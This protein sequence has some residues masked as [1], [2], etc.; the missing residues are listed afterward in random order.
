M[1]VKKIDKT[2]PD[3]AYVEGSDCIDLYVSHNEGLGLKLYNKGDTVVVNFGVAIELP[4]GYEAHIYPRSSTF[5]NT[6]LI[7]TNSVGIIDNSYNGDTDEWKGMFY[8]TQSGYLE[9]G[10]RIAQ[11]RLCKNQPKLDLEF[12]ETLG[13][14]DRGGYGST[15]K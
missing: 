3:I 10:Q 1:K 2:L 7:L 8:A 13:N 6:G 12:V 14:D 9:H 11:F 5:K 15:G 4:E